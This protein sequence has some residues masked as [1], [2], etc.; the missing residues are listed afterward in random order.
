MS[1]V[2][3]SLSG[4][5]SHQF[6]LDVIGNNLANA[7]TP[8][9]KASHVNF[10]EMMN[11]TLRPAASG[12]DSIG[13][14]NPVQIGLGVQVGTITRDFT[15][16]GL[17]DTGNPLDLAMDGRGFM[18]VHDGTRMVFIRTSTFG[19]DANNNLVD[20]VT[21]YRL[22]NVDNEPIVIPY[23]V[24]IPAQ[25]TTTV[26]IAGN[27]STA[28]DIPTTEVLVSTAPLTAG[29]TAA[30]ESTD[31]NALDSTTSSYSDGDTIL[32][33]G[34][35]IAG[36]SITPV[37]FTYGAG[38]D[39]TT[40]G[41]LI[42]VINAAFAGQ[43]TCTLDSSGNLVLTADE[44]GEASLSLTI[45]NDSGSGATDW[46][47]HALYVQ[48]DGAAGGTRRV[49]TSIYD[50]RGMAHVLTLTFERAGEREWNMI[51]SLGDE[52]GTLTTSRI[53]G[54]RFNTDGSF[55]SVAGGT[56][57]QSI[58]IDY[59]TAAE[60]QTITLQFGTVGSFDGLTAFGG[61]STAAVT[62]QDGYAA[63]TL[64]SFSIGRDGTIEGVYTNGQ[65]RELSQILVATFDNPEGLENL[66]QG[67][68]AATINSGEP[69]FGTALSGRAG[70]IVSSVL[71]ASNVES[72]E[73]LTRLI[74]A[75]HGFQLSTR[76]MAVSNR[77]I[78]ELA[79]VI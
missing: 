15:Q 23:N 16:G 66:G 79:T 24:Q 20:T 44:K 22:L 14:T 5:R 6:M 18:V 65:R 43:A 30:T 9:F 53:N 12:T 60:P 31:L 56:S 67:V 70:G 21:G 45:A 2:W 46:E 17:Q 27:L 10:A 37:T 41:D 26:T 11:Q 57:A 78:Q 51:A 74:I 8:G 35:N 1:S 62:G 58:K 50:S 19:I 73:E 7:N 64:I 47:S 76:A 28:A 34:T 29:G 68:W 42:N 48:T 39:G 25:K 4:I 38:N 36:E 55:A 61:T 3:A 54:I 75:Q 13:G 63:G 33:T 72:A 49:S 69:V 71:E 59:G 32:I 52:E 77:I 40:L